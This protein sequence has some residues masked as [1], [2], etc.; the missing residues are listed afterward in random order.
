MANEINDPA[1]LR[2]AH[3]YAR[4]QYEKQVTQSSDAGSVSLGERVNQFDRAAWEE[5]RAKFGQYPSVSNG[6]LINTENMPDWAWQLTHGETRRRP[7]YE[8]KASGEGGQVGSTDNLNL[9][10]VK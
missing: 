1:V 10:G 6:D 4:Q 2:A 5:W 8:Y 3:A 9:W 7:P